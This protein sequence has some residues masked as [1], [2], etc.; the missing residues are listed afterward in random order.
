MGVPDVRLYVLYNTILSNVFDM[1][2]SNDFIMAI[3]TTVNSYEKT[4][5]K[6]EIIYES[7]GYST[8]A[9]FT[10]FV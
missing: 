9:V 6:S 1:K 2:F 3:K 7:K 10:Y 8:A 5:R 4:R